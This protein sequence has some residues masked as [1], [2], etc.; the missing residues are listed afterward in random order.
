VLHD[1][2]RS[3]VPDDKPVTVVRAGLIWWVLAAVTVLFSLG[4]ILVMGLEDASTV[5]RVFASAVIAAIAATIVA[6]TTE[7][8]ELHGRSLVGRTILQV[9]SVDASQVSGVDDDNGLAIVLRSGR[10][11]ELG[12]CQPSVAQALIRNRRRRREAARIRTWLAGTSEPGAPSWAAATW[13]SR[14]RWP[15]VAGIVGWTVMAPLL[16]LVLASLR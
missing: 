13:D 2:I 14:V 7:R 8:W 15:A 16:T 10:R 11:L 5:D 1:G 12:I 3:T 4:V 9:L 6:T